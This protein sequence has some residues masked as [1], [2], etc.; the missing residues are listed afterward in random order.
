[1]NEL[2]SFIQSLNQRDIE[3]HHIQVEYKCDYTTLAWKI[4]PS[5]C[6]ISQILLYVPCQQNNPLVNIITN[7]TRITL[8]SETLL[9]QTTGELVDV[10]ISTLGGHN[11]PRL[12]DAVRYNGNH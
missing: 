12:L 3:L 6:S 1:M 9:D 11:C 7:Q 2:E 4:V 10:H 5:T 8:S